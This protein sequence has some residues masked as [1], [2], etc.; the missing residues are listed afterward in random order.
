MLET[1]TQIHVE[2]KILKVVDRATKRVIKKI[3]TK[4]YKVSVLNTAPL[5]NNEY[6]TEERQSLDNRYAEDNFIIG[7]KKSSKEFIR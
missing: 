6:L 4:A 7:K 3:R 5:Q 1:A 2:K